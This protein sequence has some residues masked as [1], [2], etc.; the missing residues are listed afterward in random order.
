MDLENNNL[1]PQAF[2][3]WDGGKDGGV[4]RAFKKNSGRPA[5]KVIETPLNIRLKTWVNDILNVNSLDIPR[6]IL[7][8]G[9]PGNG[10]TDAVESCIENFDKAL[11]ANGKLYEK[12]SDLNTL[13]D[14]ELSPRKCIVNFTDLCEKNNNFL[15]E[16]H[17]VQDATV[18]DP[19]RRGISPEELL[20]AELT[21]FVLGDFKGIYI[22][23]VNR[24][25]LANASSLAH[26]QNNTQLISLINELV[27]AA[28]GGPDAPNCWPLDNKNIA[29]WPM[30][31]ESLVSSS[32]STRT[33]MHQIL[34]VAL[35]EDKWQEKCSNFEQCPF[36]QNRISLSTEEAK[37]NLIKLLHYYELSSSKRW[38]FRDLYSLVSYLLR[39]KNEELTIGKTTLSPCDWTARQ[40]NI[41][42]KNDGNVSRAKAPY[43]L[44]SKLY[45]HRLFSLWPRLTKGVHREAKLSVFKRKP[46]SNLLQEFKAAENHFRALANLSVSESDTIKIILSEGFSEDLDPALLSGN[47]VIFE[48]T[49]NNK[50]ISVTAND[51][52]ERFSMSIKDGYELVKRRISEIEKL[53]LK[54]LVLADEFLMEHNH[55]PLLNKQVK[56]LQGAIR[57]FASRLVKRSLGVNLGLCKNVASFED[58]ANFHDSNF[59]AK[60]TVQKIKKLINN[61]GYFTVPLSTTFGQPV[62]HRDRNISLLVSEIKPKMVPKHSGIA[63]PQEHLPYVEI[64]KNRYIPI[65]F[66][67]FSSLIDIDKG[68][69]EASLPEEIFAMLDEVKSVIAG[70][71]VRDEDYL[72]S[73]VKIEIGIEQFSIETDD[74]LAF[75][76]DFE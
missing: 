67:L 57:K 11:C 5:D 45:S 70:E 20:N 49:E 30:D 34:D 9:G 47:T 52:D 63:R 8:I 36:C 54:N 35:D 59:Q 66:N 19:E 39:G 60:K 65:T 28:S 17:L 33:V 7:L 53:L 32:E 43:L 75:V 1:F 51:I 76:K 68:L 10:K 46:S 55:S 25:V 41:I 72:D 71:I 48:R 4:R 3:N 56:V 44:M 12:F 73:N 58:Y 14:G 29:I 31:T 23:C 2:I 69:N 13:K 74:E 18:K 64:H 21:N 24:G 62:A 42:E 22:G 27:K 16:I 61:N 38:T 15:P 40:L 50:K 26:K 37:S 6:V